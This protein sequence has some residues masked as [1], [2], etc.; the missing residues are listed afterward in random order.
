[1]CRCRAERTV[2][3]LGPS[4]KQGGGLRKANAEAGADGQ[5]A[6]EST[7][8]QNATADFYPC[9]RSRLSVEASSVRIDQLSLDAPFEPLQFAVNR[10]KLHIRQE[11][12]VCLYRV[13]L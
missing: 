11:C 13:R 1:V 10:L 6:A 9:R 8:R 5:Q 7:Q 4:A 12:A 3:R 2:R